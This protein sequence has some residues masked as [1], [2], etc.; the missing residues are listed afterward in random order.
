MLLATGGP[1]GEIPI[2]E[3]A[4]D[5]GG[6]H[7]PVESGYT[8]VTEATRYTPELGYGWLTGEITSRDR[9]TGSALERDFNFTR[10]GTCPTGRTM[11]P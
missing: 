4:F 11:S 9:M 6:S 10:E 7:S 3:A 8:R 1:N 5:F 2:G